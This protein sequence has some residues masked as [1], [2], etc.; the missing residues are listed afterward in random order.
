MTLVTVTG[1]A[2]D[3]NQI[4]IPAVNQPELWF[5]PIATSMAAGLL[6]DREIP[7]KTFSLIS[8]AFTVDLESNGELLYIPILRWLKNPEDPKNRARGQTE[9]APFNP[10]A[11]GAIDQLPGAPVGALLWWVGL[12]SDPPPAGF[13]GLWLVSGPGDPATSGSGD[14]RRVF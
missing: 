1:N 9:W 11:G 12:E 5:R 3:A 10:S 7:A 6:S 13:Q 2:W 14:V 8:G 4:A